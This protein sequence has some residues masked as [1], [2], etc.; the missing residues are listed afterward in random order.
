M[1]AHIHI[2][3][4]RIIY[5]FSITIVLLNPS[6]N[7]DYVHL[8]KMY[9]LSKYLKLLCNGGR[10]LKINGVYVNDR[11]KELTCGHSGKSELMKG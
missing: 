5:Y 1:Y 6:K 10:S 3:I 8:F 9:T 4:I 2:P 11:L 7:S